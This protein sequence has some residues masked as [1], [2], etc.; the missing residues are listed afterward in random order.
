MARFHLLRKLKDALLQRGYLEVDTAQLLPEVGTDP[1]V[2]P[3]NVHVGFGGR[4]S[5]C[6]LHTSPEFELKRLLASGFESVFEVCHVFRGGDFSKLHNPEFCMAEWYRAG[7]TYKNLMEELESILSEVFEPGP[8]RPADFKWPSK[9]KRMSIDQL[10]DR[11]LRLPVSSYQGEGEL[12]EVAHRQGLVDKTSPKSFSQ[13]FSW[14]W[15]EHIDPYL[16]KRGAIYLIDWPTALAEL[17]RCHP[18]NPQLAERFELVYKG[19]ELANGYQELT[20]P[21][22]CLERFKNDLAVRSHEKLP[23]IPLPTNFVSNVCHA[24]PFC[25]GLSL[26]VD[27][28]AMLACGV[29]NIHD[30]LSWS[31]Q[32]FDSMT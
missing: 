28:V 27:R 22:D 23:A 4:K 24:L 9:I 1:F 26:G 11:C 17:A 6:Y 12:W 14:L 13:V 29:D 5:T 20:D 15:V 7:W 31:F 3:M 2:D 32:S 30:V 21:V 10:F 19:I 18:D 16:A 25:A 8:H